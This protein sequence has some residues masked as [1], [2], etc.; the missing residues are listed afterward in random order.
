MLLGG[1]MV[2]PSFLD[3]V[4]T[5]ATYE[6]WSRFVV[7]SAVAEIALMLVMTRVMDYTIDLIAAQLNYRRSTPA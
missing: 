2:L 1:W 6:H 4:R 3:L 7:M 5:G